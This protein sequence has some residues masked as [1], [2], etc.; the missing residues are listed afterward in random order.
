MEYQLFEFSDM[1]RYLMLDGRIFIHS[2]DGGSYE[3]GDSLEYYI[4]DGKFYYIENTTYMSGKMQGDPDTMF[5]VDYD[6]NLVSHLFVNMEAL[7]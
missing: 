6:S 5:R 4:H 2:G 1:E 7:E 3:E